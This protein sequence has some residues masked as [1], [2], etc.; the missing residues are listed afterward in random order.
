MQVRHDSNRW[1]HGAILALCLSVCV[2][3]PSHA[4][5]GRISFAGAIVAPTC[6]LAAA[7]AVQAHPGQT[8]ASQAE[9]PSSGPSGQS[10][11]RAYQLRVTPLSRGMVDPRIQTY[12]QDF[13]ASPD[14]M[15]A[16]QTYR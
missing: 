16:T 11:A 12:F 4:A 8:R 7:G 5:G 3:A 9:C 2:A 6:A 15:L 1:A 10:D 13:S 14:T